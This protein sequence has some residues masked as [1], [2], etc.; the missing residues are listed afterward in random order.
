MPINGALSHAFQMHYRSLK[1][2]KTGK[3][4]H[5]WG[6]WIVK[7]FKEGETLGKKLSFQKE[8]AEWWEENK[9]KLVL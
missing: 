3:L 1:G 8:G 7:S 6:I 9:K 2:E 5:S 4:T